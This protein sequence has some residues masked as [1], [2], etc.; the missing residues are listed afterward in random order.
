[1]EV[2]RANWLVRLGFGARDLLFPSICVVCRN[3]LEQGDHTDHFCHDCFQELPLVDWPVCLRCAAQV[4]EIPGT[5]ETCVR[6]E[7]AKHAFD[8]TF[9]LGSYE[10]LL[11]EILLH[12]KTDRRELL[13]AALAQLIQCQLGDQLRALQLDAIVPGPMTTLHR[14]AR[15]TNG[16]AAVAEAVGR[17]LDG[18][19]YPRLLTKGRNASPQRGLSQAGRFRNIRGQIGT[20]AGYSLESP[21]LLLVDDIMTTG[22]TCGEAARVLKRAGASQVSVLVV[23]RTPNA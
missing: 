1:M 9:A 21:H 23:G 12:M 20:R 15:G 7:K 13:A 5:V 10:G 14:W 16:P 11:G 19:V 22:A 18:P 8:R 4:P 2:P 6:C 3:E 17:L